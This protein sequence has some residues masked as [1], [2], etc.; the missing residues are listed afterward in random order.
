MHK[1]LFTVALFFAI[2]S[3]N[4]SNN[5]VRYD[6]FAEELTD[7]SAM[8]FAP[9]IVSK[10][11]GLE[12]DLTISP[13]GDEI[14]YVVGEWPH[15]KIMHS[16]KMRRG[17]TQPDTASFS[18]G[19]YTTEPAFSADGQWL[20]FSS[21]RGKDNLFDYNLWRVKKTASGWDNP[22][23]VLDLGDDTVWEF[24]PSV[25]R[26]GEVFYC[27]W[28]SKAQKGEIYKTQCSDKGC[29]DAGKVDL[30]ISDDYGISDPYVNFDGTFM[31][32]STNIPGGYGD[33]DQYISYRGSD[34]IWSEPKNIGADYNTSGA[35]F[36]MDISADGKYII[37][38]NKDGIFLRKN[39]LTNK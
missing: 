28:N 12:A 6:L 37:T 39:S 30:S 38:Y 24:H 23:S 7:N 26:T 13:K 5:E 1:L 22:E 11:D 31:I 2:A 25:T 36:D 8:L 17:W 15:T 10:P 14:F 16:K 18:I 27:R 34:G 35:D 29:V 21:S 33:L 20:Y 19:Y 3:C 32:Y 9:G 4:T